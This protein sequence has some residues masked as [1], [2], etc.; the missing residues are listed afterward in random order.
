[1]SEL[2]ERDWELINAYAD[3]ELAAADE[4]KVAQRLTHD[5]ALSA[6]LARVHATK[7]TLSLMRTPEIAPEARSA[8]NGL[9]RIALVASLAILM[10]SGIA[11][12]HIYLGETWRDTPASLH[13]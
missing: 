12:Q 1:M 3:G 4:A 9:S 5:K 6:A 10:I 8:R 13:A 2:S 7:A 11:Y